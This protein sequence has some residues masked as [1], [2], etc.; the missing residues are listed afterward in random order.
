MMS[1][2]KV[3]GAGVRDY[4]DYLTSRSDGRAG[5]YYLG[6]D[7]EQ[8][9]QAGVWYGRATAALGLSGEVSREAL[10]RVWDGAH[11]E[12]GERL[13]SRSQR[14]VHVAAVDCT[15]SAPKSVSV[16]WA[17]SSP[18]HRAEIEAAQDRAVE[19]ALGH[20]EKTV[21]PVRRYVKGECRHERA[22]GLVVARFRHHTS[23]V[24][25]DQ[26]AHGQAP[27]PQLH[28]HCA[29]ANMALRRSDAVAKNGR[30]AAVDSHAFFVARAEAG[31]VYRAELAA[32]LQRLGYTVER[33]GK[34]FE[35]RGITKD[36]RD[37]FS[38]REQE[39]K[40]AEA[41]FTAKHGRK[42][43][44]AEMRTLVVTTRG[45]KDGEQPPAFAQWVERAREAGLCAEDVVGLRGEAGGGGASVREVA[46]SVVRELSDLSSE[47]SL[48]RMDAAV[49]MPLARAAIAEAAQTR[50]GGEE[51]AE[52][53]DRVLASPELVEV[54]DRVT[55]EAMLALERSVLDRGVAMARS[56]DAVIAPEVVR[57]VVEGARV[58]LSEEQVRAVERLSEGRRLSLVTAPAGAGKGEVLRVVAEG[59]RRS[60]RRVVALSAA[61]ETAQRLGAEIEA[62]ETRTIDSFIYR[63]RTQGETGDARTVLVV[64]E[65]ALMETARWSCLLEAAGDAVVI[66]AGDD[67]QLSPIEA[68]GIWGVLARQVG[69]V[70]LEHNYRAREEAMADAWTLLREG[71]S[72]PALEEYERRG[73][74]EI[75]GTR[76]DAVVRAVELWDGGRRD[77]A[78]AGRGI[79][80]YLLLTDSSNHEVDTLNRLAQAKRDLAGELGT[81]AV[82]VVADDERTG[83]H[84]DEVVRTGDRVV[85]ERR[86]VP[87]DDEGRKLRRVENGATGEVVR[88]EPGRAVVV[89]TGDREVAVPG[90]EVDALRLGYAQHVYSA[91]GRTVEQSYVLAG[92]WHTDRERAYV[93]MSRSRGPSVVVT[94]YSSLGVEEGRREEALGVLSARCGTSRAK[95]AAVSL[96]ERAG[97]GV[98]RGVEVVERAVP[99]VERGRERA[100]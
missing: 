40:E 28:D 20:I 70:E 100:A 27:D 64:D 69:S 36:V 1:V 86:F 42:P 57:A 38:Q 12:S 89:R 17:L 24:C 99:L 59:H 46:R 83:H 62:D 71:A 77:G 92:T 52:L 41:A 85:F 14:G 84:R 90:Q 43:T 91:Q 94:D 50:L 15:F 96:V 18:E 49:K 53:I 25:G 8:R 75:C 51:V 66:A 34:Y 19:V 81:D 26:E 9:E 79:E 80:Q 55:T 10:M 2:R 30:W 98:A 61:G 56:G 97:R 3:G 47:T 13:V 88:I 45:R 23:R 37:V 58:P 21:E 60:G 11:P 82:R 48:T 65:A 22:E 44:H 67:R 74:I 35:I 4:A 29:I 31:A 16:V 7:G 72:A 63:A 54:G 5:D 32:G 68:G 95:E 93:G 87:L 73:L 76:G 33:E 6:R 78:E 39:V